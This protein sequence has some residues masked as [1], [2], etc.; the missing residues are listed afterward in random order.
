MS[1]MT[2]VPFRLF[3]HIGAVTLVGVSGLACPAVTRAQVS[4]ETIHQFGDD[5]GTL[6]AGALIQATDGRF[7]GTTT[8][9]G[10]SDLG[11]VFQLEP[12]GTFTVLHDF[13]GDADG[14]NSYAPL[15]QASDG[16]F[17]GTTSEGGPCGLGT[18]F[19]LAPGGTFNTLHAFAG[20]PD[21]GASPFS[22]PF[23]ATAGS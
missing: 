19:R 12:D 11:T 8:Y 23:H 4:L 16:N 10:A 13:T 2:G 7:Y 9:G 14:A 22:A 1:H 21:N 17:Y 5:D 6:P 15:I 20:G 18:I 3:A